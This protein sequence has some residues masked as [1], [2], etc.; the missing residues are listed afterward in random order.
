MRPRF[1]PTAFL[2]VLCGLL[3]PAV[4]QAGYAV[5]EGVPITQGELIVPKA[6]IERLSPPQS[7][8][9]NRFV[10][11]E[12]RVNA[13]V[14]GVVA[15]VQ[16]Q[17]V[18][19][20]PYQ[21]R[22]EAIYVFP[23]PENAAVDRYSIEL[24]ERVIRGIVERREKARAMYEQARQEGRVGGLLEQERANVFTQSVANIPPGE[25]VTVNIEYV[26]P[27]DVDGD[28]YAFRFPMVVAPRYMPGEPTSK[29]SVGRG[30]ARD[31]NQVPDASRISPHALPPGQRNGNDVFIQVHIDAGMPI[32]EIVGVT[33][34]IDTVT[35]SETQAIVTLKNQSTIADK[36]FL[37]E[38]RLASDQ[39]VLASL[40]HRTGEQ[41]YFALMLQ[42]K[43]QISEAELAPREVILLLDVS[44]S[45]NGPG[46]SQLRIFSEHLLDEL[47]PQDTFRV[48]SFSTSTR[49]WTS[50]PQP[51]TPENVESAKRFV[52]AL[53]PGGG[54]NLLP[55]LNTALRSS[56]DEVEQSRYL[57]L[58][59]D[60]LVGNDHTILNYF[61]Q[62]EV[63]DVR[64][65][66]VAFGAAPNH[67][68]ISRAA[69]IGRGFSMQV[70]NQDNPAELVKRFNDKASSPY[71]TDVEID[72]GA[73]QVT[74]VIPQRL[75]D[76]YAGKPLLIAGRYTEA[77]SSE[78]T[79]RGNILGQKVELKM[80]ME[81]PEEEQAHDALGTVWARQRIRQIWNEN[82][83]RSTPESIE[84][85]TR[86]G[87]EHQLVTQ[88]TSFV[89]V[90]ETAPATVDGNLL[91]ESVRVMTPEG[92]DDVT[93]KAGQQQR[94]VPPVKQ[95]V[96]SQPRQ[97][98]SRPATTPQPAAKA[99]N[100]PTP[101]RQVAAAPR[102]PSPSYSPAPAPSQSA[103]T[104]STPSTSSSSSRRGGGGFGG[105]GAV[106]WVFLAGLGALAAGRRQA[107]KRNDA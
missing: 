89:A 29:P 94:N 44:G 69:E 4:C 99:S 66:P 80:P 25:R 43:W 60:A 88:Y 64:V 93:G 31:T 30:W 9:T 61:Q 95:P 107:L 40:A 46:I 90:E 1:R 86:L 68:L 23:L 56:T 96:N 55:A 87:L 104:R 15:R 59:T 33:H 63:A 78:V 27:L 84:E 74:D 22:L 37:L 52:R 79:L 36:D 102:T 73:L 45:M 98:A 105:G 38:Y 103:A 41:G 34:E 11:A 10:L 77:A 92:M 42:P 7:T 71:L 49:E 17:Q 18:F 91:T 5:L 13:E 58:L 97:V 85:I 100:S 72:W 47:R 12:T 53:R 106:E 101:P 6:E 19:E 57:F 32:H 21:E 3:A 83:G 62:P 8:A 14:S 39:T 76:V 70:T 65:F 16:V 54:T 81:L 35:S 48:L 75:P 51:A 50:A 26:Q 2:C 24:D 67:Y 82:V 28:H 20:N